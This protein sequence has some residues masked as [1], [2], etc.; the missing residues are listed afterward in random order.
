M[1][2]LSSEWIYKYYKELEKYGRKAKVTA[3]DISEDA[4]ALA[5]ENAAANDAD[6]LFIQS[7]LFTRIRGRFDIIITNPPYIPT[8]TVETLQ[9]EVKDYEPHLALDGGED[10]M[11]FYRR[12]AEEAG[13]YLTRGGMLIMEVGEG[14][15]QEVVK[16]FKGHAYAMVSQDFNGIERYVKIIM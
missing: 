2:K 13:K 9:K 6:V 5:K 4:L 14:E 10:G 3:V 11:D 15:A 7:D 1:K 16:M 8:A 12:I